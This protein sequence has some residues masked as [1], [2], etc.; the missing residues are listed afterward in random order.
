MPNFPFPLSPLLWF[1]FLVAQ[2][3]IWKSGRQV[4]CAS[5]CYLKGKEQQDPENADLN[6]VLNLSDRYM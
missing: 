4:F 1:H 5:G 6:L 3:P 2:F